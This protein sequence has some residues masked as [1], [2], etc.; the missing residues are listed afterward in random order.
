MSSEKYSTAPVETLETFAFVKQSAESCKEPKERKLQ[1]NNKNTLG[2]NQSATGK[3]REFSGLGTLDCQSYSETRDYDVQKQE[4][5]D[6]FSEGAELTLPGKYR[7]LKATS[8]RLYSEL[9]NIAE[10]IDKQTH[11]QRFI[12]RLESEFDMGDI[13]THEKLQ[14]KANGLL[15]EHEKLTRLTSEVV[16]RS[17]NLSEDCSWP[18][19]YKCYRHWQVVLSKFNELQRRTQQLLEGKK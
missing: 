10:K 4:S 9:R 17:Y 3:P 14:D 19:V 2:L 15:D 13:S 16:N 12:D 6:P 7:K 1:V 8:T 5:F 18:E 11:C